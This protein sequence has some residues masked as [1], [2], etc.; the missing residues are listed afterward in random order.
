MR[1]VDRRLRRRRSETVPLFVSIAL[2]LGYC[3]W[4]GTKIVSWTNQGQP[5]LTAIGLVPTNPP[6][7]QGPTEVEVTGSVGRR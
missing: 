5:G 7:V 3:I 4:T 6:V 1:P 2:V